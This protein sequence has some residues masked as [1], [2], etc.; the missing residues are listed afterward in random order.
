M[1]PVS[2][3]TIFSTF[4]HE[5]ESKTQGE[6]RFQ[7]EKKIRFRAVDKETP[8]NPKNARYSKV[9]SSPFFLSRSYNTARVMDLWGKC[10]G[11]ASQTHD[12]ELSAGPH[13]ISSDLSWG[14]PLPLGRKNASLRHS[15]CEGLFLLLCYT[16]TCIVDITA[17]KEHNS[18]NGLKWKTKDIWK[19]KEDPNEGDKWRMRSE[20][21]AN[22]L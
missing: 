12:Q 17:L 2:L 10:H 3:S 7:W 5:V 14:D 18:L 4:S 8:S 15:S 22:A 9:L 16:D 20:V 13:I 11:K 1:S 6:S 19:C 21:Q